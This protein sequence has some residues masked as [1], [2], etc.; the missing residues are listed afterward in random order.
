MLTSHLSCWTR[1][2]N[3]ILLLTI[4]IECSFGF[5][6]TTNQTVGNK[7]TETAGVPV[8][9]EAIRVRTG[10]V[11]H[12]VNLTFNAPKYETFPGSRSVKLTCT[13]L[14][15][16]PVDL[17]W[18][19]NFPTEQATSS[20]VVSAD[21]SKTTTTSGVN[22]VNYNRNVVFSDNNYIGNSSLKYF[23][24]CST[25]ESGDATATSSSSS[26]EVVTTSSLTVRD[27]TEQ[28]MMAVYECVCNIYK[29]CVNQAVSS[30]ATLVHRYSPFN[31]RNN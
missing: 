13:G 30:N 1:A 25:A 4:L 16:S 19:V 11:Q 27:V 29:K 2:F 8:A 17:V 24:E 10:T 12:T 23:V 7:L 26:G 21:T 14:N 15:L 20:M 18:I 22:R 5:T 31:N 6:N 28:D 9:T 3:L